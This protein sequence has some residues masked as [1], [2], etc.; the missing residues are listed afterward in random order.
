MGSEPPAFGSS[1]LEQRRTVN[2]YNKPAPRGNRFYFIR[3]FNLNEATTSI[4][5]IKTAT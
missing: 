1:Q 3:I 5:L 4:P 2:Y